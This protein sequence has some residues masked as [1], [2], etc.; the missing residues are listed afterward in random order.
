MIVMIVVMLVLVFMQSTF[1]VVVLVIIRAGHK[2]FVSLPFVV[3][4]DDQVAALLA[5]AA[6]ATTSVPELV[7]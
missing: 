1:R 7:T 3:H 6:L 2:V 5:F 4:P